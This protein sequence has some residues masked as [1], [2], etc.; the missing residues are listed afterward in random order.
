VSTAAGFA[1]PLDWTTMAGCAATTYDWIVK[2]AD[3]GATAVTVDL[4]SSVAGQLFVLELSG[5][6]QEAEAASVA[7]TGAGSTALAA[8]VDGAPGQVVISTI[9]T[10][11]TVAAI[12]PG[13]PFVTFA[14][15]ARGD[16]AYYV[17]PATGS[18][19]A[20]WMLDRRRRL[21]DAHRFVPVTRGLLA[22][23]A[24]TDAAT[25]S[26]LRSMSRSTRRWRGARARCGAA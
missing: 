14:N 22:S 16:V 26:G 6:S 1:D 10:C 13:S 21:A 17:P 11:G 5:V 20:A 15:T 4:P 23:G 25:A 2:S 24:R 19:G 7:P 12:A 9:S 8:Q 3:P 18:Y